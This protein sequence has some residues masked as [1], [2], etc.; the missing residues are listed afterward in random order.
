MALIKT[1][2]GVAGQ[3][4]GNCVWI[5]RS[6]DVKATIV[7]AN[8]FNGMSAALNIGDVIHVFS[9]VGGTVVYTLVGVLANAAGVVT[10]GVPA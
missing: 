2:M 6:A 10:V 9:G 8:Y 1:N 7:A 3:A 4:G 5:Y